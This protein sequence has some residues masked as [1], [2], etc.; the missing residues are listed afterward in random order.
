M[1]SAEFKM[2]LT[3]EDGDTHQTSVIR[4]VQ[5]NLPETKDKYCQSCT[6]SSHYSSSSYGHSH[7]V[8]CSCNEDHQDA[9]D[10]IRMVSFTH[11]ERLNAGDSVYLKYVS[12]GSWVGATSK[13]IFRGEYISE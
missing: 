8:T 3:L 9:E 2:E 13:C 7:T 11:Y 6:S 5:D 10:A 12:G 4:N 1:K